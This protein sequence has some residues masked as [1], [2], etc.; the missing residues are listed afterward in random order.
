MSFSLA[1]RAV[2]GQF[3]KLDGHNYGMCFHLLQVIVRL[4]FAIR[5]IRIL[6]ELIVILLQFYNSS[7]LFTRMFLCCDET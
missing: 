3:V 7:S 6:I 1:Y 2:I 5:I 4:A